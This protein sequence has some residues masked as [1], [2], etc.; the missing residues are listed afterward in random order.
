M[1]PSVALDLTLAEHIPVYLGASPT[2]L[3][4]EFTKVIK[5]KKTSG[6]SLFSALLQKG[7]A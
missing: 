2:V 5:K 4:P 6:F 3:K 1:Q 7:V